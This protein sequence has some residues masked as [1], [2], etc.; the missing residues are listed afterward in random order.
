MPVDYLYFFASPR[1]PYR[2]KIG[3][4]DTPSRRRREVA[5]ALNCWVVGF[6]L[7]I[8]YARKFEMALHHFYRKGKAEMPDHSGKEE[9]VWYINPVAMI[10][11]DLWC[12]GHG[13]ELGWFW[14]VLPIIIPLP[15]DVPLCIALYWLASMWVLGRVICFVAPWVPLLERIIWDFIF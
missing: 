10:L 7:P 14:Y 9:W 4:S 3:I 11:F 12:Y 2:V 5:S 6:G 13:V 1:Y 15:L 8:P